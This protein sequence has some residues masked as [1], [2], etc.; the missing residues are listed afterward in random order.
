MES[1]D[2]GRLVAVSVAVLVVRGKFVGVQ[3]GT[4]PRLNEQRTSELTCS[5]PKISPVA[6][7][8]VVQFLEVADSSYLRSSSIS[9]SFR[10]VMYLFWRRRH[11]VLGSAS[12]SSSAPIG[13]Q[14][15]GAGL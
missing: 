10:L 11:L 15:Q 3:T 1:N 6:D 9:P 7:I 14:K 13:P 12:G 5:I 2:A 8:R 4:Y